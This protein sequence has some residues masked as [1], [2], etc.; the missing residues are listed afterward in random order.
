MARFNLDDYETVE[1]RLKRARKELPGLRVVTSLVTTNEDRER[2][3]WIVQAFLYKTSDPDEPPFASGLAFETDGTAGAN[4]TSA[5][6]NAETSAIGRALANGG[7]SGNKRASRE[8]M[9]KANRGNV[10]TFPVQTPTIDVQKATNVD[11]LNAL[12]AEAV[13]TGQSAELKDAFSKRKSEL[14]DG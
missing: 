11:E 2:K 6:E 9:A 3:Q 10:S 1:D 14:L 13:A 8:E 4:M 5:L 7:F 12:W